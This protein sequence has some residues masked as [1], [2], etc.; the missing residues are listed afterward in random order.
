MLNAILDGYD[1]MMKYQSSSFTKAASSRLVERSK[2]V[3][4]YKKENQK[5]KHCESQEILNWFN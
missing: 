4:G 1:N 5:L 2:Q 3:S